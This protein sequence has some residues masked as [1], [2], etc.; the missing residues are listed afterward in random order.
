MR[1]YSRGV[2]VFLLL[3]LSF[4]LAFFLNLLWEV[5]H[6]ALYDWNRLP[7]RND[8][9]FY[10]F[11]ILRATLTDAFVILGMFLFNSALRR[12]LDWIGKA[13][14][15]D[16]LIISFL[17]LVIAVIIEIRAI[18]LNLWSYNEF[19]PIVFGIGLTPM[20]QLAITGIAV[21]II[22]KKVKG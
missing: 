10:I 19:M 8:V 7:L 11:R 6:S 5:L 14:I 4:V 13:K 22:L 16:Y 17:G 15:I 3:A 21:L 9:Y 12:D 20:I 1:E 18:A 2:G